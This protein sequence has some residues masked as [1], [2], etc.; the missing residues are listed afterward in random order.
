[1]LD[2]LSVIRRS[3]VFFVMALALLVACSS[4]DS[5][6]IYDPLDF[7]PL[8]EDMTTMFDKNNIVDQAAFTDI[9]G[10]DAALV[11]TFLHRTPYARP[12][13]LETYQSNGVRA[14]DA[15]LRAARTYRINPLVFL[16]AAEGQQGLL[17]AKDYPFPPNR[18][19]YVFDCGCLQGE[20]C[21]P[22]LAG[23]DRQVD[24][25]GRNLR[26]ALDE[27]AAD[28]QTASGWGQDKTSTTLDGEKVTPANAAT[29]AVYAMVPN[30]S[31]GSAGGAWFFWNVYRQYALGIDYGGPIG[32]ASGSWI[33]EKC[34]SDASCGGYDSAKCAQNYPDGLCTASCSGDCPSKAGQAETFCV[35]FKAEGGFCFEKCNLG[36]PSCRDGYTCKQLAKFGSTSVNDAKPVCYPTSTTP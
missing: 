10:I 13:F 36:S 9:D 17:A 31:V 26:K 15:I 5:S 22:A 23:F 21:L 12:S 29:A 2:G 1:M 16:V 27:M 8:K 18:V 24:C 20:N 28:G 14:G 30:V 25:L 3:L 6:S 35:D 4:T 33:G 34:S 32:G 11:Q 19:E 7:Q